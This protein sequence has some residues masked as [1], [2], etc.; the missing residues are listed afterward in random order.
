VSDPI[1]GIAAFQALWDGAPLNPAQAQ[2]A[3]LLLQVAS[4]WIVAQKPGIGPDDPAAKLVAYEVTANALRYGKYAS[5]KSWSRSTLHKMDS[6]TLD[7]PS[8]ALDFT[9]RHRS[10][11][12][13]SL[14]SVPIGS[15]AVNDFDDQNYGNPAI[16]R[17]PYLG[18]RGYDAGGY[19]YR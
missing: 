15:F 12:G 3:T 7:D 9:D 4:N 14:R 8:S 11:L 6:G 10:L 5:L 1:L 19:G 16:G 17:F 13:L 2:V 18:G